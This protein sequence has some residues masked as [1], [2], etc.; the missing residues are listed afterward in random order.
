MPMPLPHLTIALAD[1]DLIL[2]PP[3]S[4]PMIDAATDVAAVADDDAC[5]DSPGPSTAQRAALKLMKSPVHH[6]GA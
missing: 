6:G 3:D 1:R 4:V 2:P 5:G